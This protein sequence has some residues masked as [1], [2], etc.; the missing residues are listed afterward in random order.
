MKPIVCFSMTL[1]VA[2]AAATQPLYTAADLAAD[3]IHTALSRQSKIASLEGDVEL[4]YTASGDSQSFRVGFA[5]VPPGK[6]RLEITGLLGEILFVL[7]ADGDRMMVHNKAER[8]AVVCSA[9]RDNL[10]ALLGMDLGGDIYQVLDW[11]EGRVPMHPEEVATGEILV[12]AEEDAD[13]NATVTWERRDSG[14]T[15]Q[16]ITISPDDGRVLFSRVYDADGRAEADIYYGDF[17]DCDGFAM[18][19]YVSVNREDTYLDVRFNKVRLNDEIK[20]R[21]FS[22]EPPDGTEVFFWDDLGE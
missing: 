10:T 16:I 8:K 22:V 19:Y 20:E 11:I 2:A 9:T 21:A 18:P 17:G 14:T 3:V 5:R 15:V 1:L 7:T 4:T 12:A 6:A 13:G